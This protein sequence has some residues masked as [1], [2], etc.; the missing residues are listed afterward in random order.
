MF[1][2]KKHLDR[3]TFLRGMGATIALPWLD[4][5][6]PARTA[7]AAGAARS[8]PRLLFVYFP[9]GAVMNE[10]APREEGPLG[11]LGAILEPLSPFKDRLSIIGG[12]ENKNAYGPVHAIT[13]GTWLSGTSPRGSSAATM[14]EGGATVGAV[15]ALGARGALGATAD[16]IAADRIGRDTAVPSIELAT[17][18]PREICAGVWEGDYHKCFGTTLSFNGLSSPRPMEFSP[19]KVFD[20]LFAS[21]PASDRAGAPASVLDR[22]AEDAAGLQKR[23]GPADQS[24][25]RDYLEALRDVEC[26]VVQAGGSVVPASDSSCDAANAFPERVR[27]MFDIIALAFQADITRIASFMMAAETSPMTYD[28][29]GVPESFHLLSHHQNDPEKLEK[30]VRIQRYHTSAFASF[31]RRLDALKEAEGSILDRSLILYGSNMSDSH[32]HDHFPLPAAL[33]GGGC[34]ASGGQYRRYPDRTPLS[35]LLL[36]MLHRA[37]VP[38][39]S[40][41]DST[42]ECAGV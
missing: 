28:H 31:V 41:G 21:G 36:T 9:H 8:T 10:W 27:L 35:N 3:R 16:Q 39:D 7:L 37:G 34:G 12:L 25:L 17:E 15:G 6:L 23:L 33:V 40:V 26:R 13:P 14:C 42:G 29:I 5:M 20:R 22:V 4:A 2:A 19:R 11:R 32:A 24:R 38:V 30:L 18:A 1:I